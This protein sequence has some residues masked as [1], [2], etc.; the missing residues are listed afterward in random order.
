MLRRRF[1]S[2]TRP[3][4]LD[5]LKARL[6]TGLALGAEVALVV[7]SA[8]VAVKTMRFA[9]G[10]VALAIYLIARIGFKQR[11]QRALL[12]AVGTLVLTVAVAILVSKTLASPT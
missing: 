4:W 1:P 5:R 11:P 2:P 6:R 8:L 9:G 7:A 3:T 10:L 12:W